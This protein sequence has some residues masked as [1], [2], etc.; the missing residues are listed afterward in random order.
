METGS[1]KDGPLPMAGVGVEQVQDV[2]RQPVAPPTSEIVEG[3]T[4][5]GALL[6]FWKHQGCGVA[7]CPYQRESHSHCE[8]CRCPAPLDPTHD[9]HGCGFDRAKRHGKSDLVTLSDGVTSGWVNQSGNARAHY[10]AHENPKIPK[11]K[12]RSEMRSNKM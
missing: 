11:K 2:L 12:R 7:D 1:S 10:E 9:G 3:E 5:G 8:R 4:P 6:T